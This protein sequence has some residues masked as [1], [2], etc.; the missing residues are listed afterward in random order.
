MGG[1]DLE[2][3]FEDVFVHV[4]IYGS[5]GVASH[6][7]TRKLSGDIIPCEGSITGLE[8]STQAVNYST[9]GREDLAVINM[10]RDCAFE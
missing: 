2:D 3:G 1:A 8:C 6:D 7:G 5:G 10:H 4:E 9:A